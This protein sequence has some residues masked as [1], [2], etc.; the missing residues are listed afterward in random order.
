MCFNDRPVEVSFFCCLIV[1]ITMGSGKNIH[2]LHTQEREICLR[3]IVFGFHTSLLREL[4]PPPP[5]QSI[6]D[7]RW[8]RD[9]APAGSLVDDTQVQ[10]DR[11]ASRAHINRLIVSPPPK[12]TTLWDASK[13]ST[14]PGCY[15]RKRELYDSQYV[16]PRNGGLGEQPLPQLAWS[17]VV[18]DATHQQPP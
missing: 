8:P 9:G 17:C 7:S 6:S 16:A 10:V 13:A 2:N 5:T 12:L 14:R 4:H 15:P 11:C 18:G 3:L 1:C